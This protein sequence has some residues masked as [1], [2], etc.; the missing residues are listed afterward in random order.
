M[1]ALSLLRRMICQ[2]LQDSPG[3]DNILLSSREQIKIL[4][5]LPLPAIDAEWK[6]IFSSHLLLRLLPSN[7]RIATGVARV[8]SSCIISHG[9]TL[10]EN[11]TP[12]LCLVQLTQPT[13]SFEMQAKETAW[14]PGDDCTTNTTP[15]DTWR[16]FSRFRTHRV[17]SEFKI[18]ELLWKIGSQRNVSMRYT[19]RNGP[20]CQASDDNLVAAMFRLM[21]NSQE[22]TV[23]SPMRTKASRSCSTDC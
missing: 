5:T 13:G 6:D 20:P 11:S 15:C 12:T 9:V 7:S 14:K 8:S 10:L 17:V 18:W 21:P 19:D 22:E 4:Q 16:S 3:N 23:C 1:I 2:Q